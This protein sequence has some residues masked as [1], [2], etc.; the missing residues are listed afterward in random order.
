MAVVMA[1]AA[2]LTAWATYQGG[3]WDSDAAAARSNSAILRSDAG[4]AAADAVTQSVIDATIWVEWEKA[5]ML[6]RGTLAGFL[7]DRF[8]PALD[9][10]QDA[11]LGRTA[12][13][14]DGNPIG[15]GLPA[16][17]P[18]ALDAYTPPAQLRAD[19]LAARAEDFLARADADS[20]ISSRFVM[21]AVLLA[22][23][24]F[25]GS[26]ATKFGDVRL[27]AAMAATAVLM[28]AVSAARLVSLPVLM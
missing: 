6:D 23:V 27:Q 10:A 7:R 21:Q 5:V 13:D 22:L 20:T 18:L 9:A 19:E 3:Q 16:G 11:W 28:M 14:A 8:S 25:F 24:L 4:R 1:A 17:T 12:V 2:V 26:A 15:G